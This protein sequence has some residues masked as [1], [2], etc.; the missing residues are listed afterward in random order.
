MIELVKALLTVPAKLEQLIEDLRIAR[1]EQQATGREV[2]RA[3]RIPSAFV[4][5][6]VFASAPVEGGEFGRVVESASCSLQEHSPEAWLHFNAQRPMKNVQ[7][8]VIC[9]LARVQ[10]EAIMAGITAAS[11]GPSPV[12]YFGTVELG[13]QVGARVRL[14]GVV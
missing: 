7:V 11:L 9:D 4:T 6:L 8:L 10:V 13:Q 3:L 12:G 2:A 1:V 5:L 14:R